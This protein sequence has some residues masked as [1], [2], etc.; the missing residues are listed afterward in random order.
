VAYTKVFEPLTSERERAAYRQ[1]NSR[2]CE[3]DGLIMLFERQMLSNVIHL[4]MVYLT[5]L[6]PSDNGE[7]MGVQ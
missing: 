7:K 2:D 6:C 4:F 1:A 5:M 3:T